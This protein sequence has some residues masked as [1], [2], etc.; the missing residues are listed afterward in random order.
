[1]MMMII[2][3]IIIIAPQKCIWQKAFPAPSWN[4]PVSTQAHLDLVWVSNLR[5]V[6]WGE[7]LTSRACAVLTA[8]LAKQL[9]VFIC[10]G[11]RQAHGRPDIIITVRHSS[12]DLWLLSTVSDG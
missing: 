1:M 6:S 10:H 11:H 5:M 9:P 2:I 7:G 12:V 8:T 3:I 4:R